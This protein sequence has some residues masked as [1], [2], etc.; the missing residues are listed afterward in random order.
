MGSVILFPVRAETNVDARSSASR[1]KVTKGPVTS[2]ALLLRGAPAYLHPAAVAAAMV[3]TGSSAGAVPVWAARKADFSALVVARGIRGTD[4][5]NLMDEW[6]ALVR[7]E[8]IAEKARRRAA[9]G[10]VFRL[11]ER[12]ADGVPGGGDVA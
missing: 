4:I 9:E 5:V 10:K 3:A 6:R 12:L 7:V 2:L 1:R 8:G 11:F